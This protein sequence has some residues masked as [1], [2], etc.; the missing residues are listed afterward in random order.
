MGLSRA[1]SVVAQS[2]LLL[3]GKDGK[4]APPPS[5][6]PVGRD[7]IPEGNLWWR[8]SDVRESARRVALVIPDGEEV[9]LEQDKALGADDVR[10]RP[11][12]GWR[13]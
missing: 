3:S 12:S 4:D 8:F 10:T 1:K 9:E 6:P 2:A 13:C 11:L 5:A 7:E